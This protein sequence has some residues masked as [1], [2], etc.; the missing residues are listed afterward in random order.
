MYQFADQV[1]KRLYD[2]LLYP[3]SK[4]FEKLESAQSLL[5]LEEI[6]LHNQKR[7]KGDA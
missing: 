4:T 2:E 1:V 5:H 7:T 3:L 6:K